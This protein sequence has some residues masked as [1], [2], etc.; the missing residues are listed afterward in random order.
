[1]S[2]GRALTILADFYATQEIMAMD[3]AA[4]HAPSECGALVFKNRDRDYRRAYRHARAVAGMSRRKFREMVRKN[5]RAIDRAMCSIV[6][7]KSPW[8]V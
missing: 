6:N 7:R 3:L 2:K 8:M 4:F 5:H 1:M